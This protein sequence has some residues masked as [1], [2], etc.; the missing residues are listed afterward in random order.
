MKLSYIVP[1]YN[2]EK[3]IKECVDS[4]LAQ[5]FDDYEVILVDDESPDGCPRIC[6]EYAERFPNIIKVIHQKNKGLAGA[7]NSG[8]EKAKGDY[9]CFFDSDDYFIG[10]GIAEIY[11]K[12][13]ECDADILQNSFIAH[14]ELKNSKFTVR[15][16]FN[17][18]KIYI[19]NE[20][21]EKVRTSTTERSTIYVWRNIYKR[22]FLLKNNISFDEK[23]RMIEDSPFNTLAF[24]RAERMVAVDM[25][26]YAYRLRND[27]LQR[28]KYIEAYDLIM[29]YQWRLRRKYYREYSDNDALFY[30]DFAEF[31]LKTNLYILLANIY[32]SDIG[33]KYAML[34]RL[35]DSEMIR[36]SFEEYDINNYKSKA[37]DWW[38]TFFIKRRFY[39][40]AH[41]I[42][43]KT[44]YK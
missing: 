10:D 43:K 1:V 41:L 25:P 24:L 5:T 38:T 4:I 34:K 19:H 23:L 30:K 20:I 21:T 37:L 42:C 16:A 28:K 3:Y 14:N 11:Q 13:V 22:S 36:T 6:D 35:G 15:S 27:S 7:R 44:L 39:L 17:T 18:G 29:E 8:L 2:V 31:V 40:L 9:V 26:I 32:S 33:N 12:A